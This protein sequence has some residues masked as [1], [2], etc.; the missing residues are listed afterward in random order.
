MR[1]II[2]MYKSWLATAALVAVLTAFF[3]NGLLAA[4]TT[5]SKPATIQQQTPA[6]GT[7]SIIA[8]LIG[9]VERQVAI[10]VPSGYRAGT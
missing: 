4:P 5:K 10:Y 8:I 1:I 7:L 6:P 9:L 2:P 3:A